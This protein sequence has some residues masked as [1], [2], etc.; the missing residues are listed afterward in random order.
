MKI[1]RPSSSVLLSVWMAFRACAPVLNSTRPQPLERPCASCSTS[2]RVT[3]LGCLFYIE[4]KV[5]TDIKI[6][7]TTPQTSLNRLT[8]ARLLHV[9]L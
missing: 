1:W 9:V 6:D 2:A 4:I 8:L 3:V 5:S 7:N